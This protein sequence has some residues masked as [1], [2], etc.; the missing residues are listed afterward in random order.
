MLYKKNNIFSSLEKFKNKS[1]IY[2]DGNLKSYNDLLRDS[3]YFSILFRSKK[4]IIILADNSYDFLV[5]YVAA[6]RED[7]VILLIDPNIKKKSFLELQ[8]KYLPEY[9][10]CRSNFDVPSNYKTIKVFNNYSLFKNVFHHN[11][12]I[13]K[14]IS[15]LL[16]TSGT[17]GHT[18][19]VKLSSKNLLSNCVAISKVFKIRSGDITITTMPAYYSYALSIIN[20]YLMNGATIIL[21]NYSLLDKRFWDI[22]KKIKPTNING[23]PYFYEILNKIKFERIKIMNLRYITQA[24]GKLEYK[25]KKKLHNFCKLNKIKFYIMYGQ[26]EASPRISIL[27]PRLLDSHMNSVGLPLKGVKVWIEDENKKRINKPNVEGNIICKG[28][29]VFMGYSESFKDLSDKS[30]NNKTLETGDVGYI[31]RKGLIFITGRKKRIVKV[32]GIRISLDCLE[33]SLKKNNYNCICKGNDDKIK[34]YI[35]INNKN[36]LNLL[37]FNNTLKKLTNLTTNFYQ[38]KIVKNFP[39]NKIGKIIYN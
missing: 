24:G 27:P 6:I 25:L 21:N 3:N 9:I 36:K 18:K 26:T 1:A 23:V 4:I 20:T 29:N 13:N 31:N 14:E 5:C 22:F 39:R 38:V 30:I 7:L 35:K 11:Y 10:F 28:N 19:F 8:K 16:N 32:F 33:E 37:K 15:C 2:Y 17:M 12:N 34:I